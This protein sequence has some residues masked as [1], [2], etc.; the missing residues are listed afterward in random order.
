MD[1]AGVYPKMPR[2]RLK[3]SFGIRPTKMTGLNSPIDLRK[4]IERLVEIPVRDLFDLSYSRARIG[5]N[6]TF[7]SI[8]NIIFLEALYH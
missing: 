6:I 1:K 5:R 3:C 4:E 7:S 2:S 8:V